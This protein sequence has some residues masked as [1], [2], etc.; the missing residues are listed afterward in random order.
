MSSKVWLCECG[1]E[2]EYICDENLSQCSICKA[3][4]RWIEID[5][6]CEHCADTG[7]VWEIDGYDA[8]C[9]CDAADKK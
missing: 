4:G 8:C 3:V 6:P 9:F 5:V 7:R 2:E 1:N